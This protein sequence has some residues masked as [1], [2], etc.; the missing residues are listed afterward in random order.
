MSEERKKILEMLGDGKITVDEAER[1]LNAL[2]ARGGGT[3]AVAESGGGVKATPKY[4]RVLVQGGEDGNV[5][6]RVPLALIRAGMKLGA[7]IPDQAKEHIDSALKN[8][9][10]HFDLGKADAKT[11][12]E[13]IQ[14]LADLTVDVDGK[15]G[16]K[17]RVF[18]E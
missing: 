17:V 4:L 15:D 5:N 8:K 12:E 10:I 9:G 3:S 1:L 13:L 16:E 6:V 2:A 18:C 11:L 7:I 14:H